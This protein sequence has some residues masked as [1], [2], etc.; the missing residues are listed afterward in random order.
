MM[1]REEARAHFSDY[2]DDELTDELRLAFEQALEADEL[3][4]KEFR[5]FRKTVQSL[6][7]LRMTA[8][9][10]EFARKVERRIQRRS[11]GRFFREQRILMR[12]PFE[13]FSFVI[14]LI[15]LVLY[16]TVM[17]EGKK[18]RKPQGK[19][20]ATKQLKQAPSSA[21]HSLPSPT[22]EH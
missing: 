11:R 8:P 18:V 22:S 19:P 5:S 10:P 2:L 7:G 9:P 17:L 20:P 6:S 15:L 16:M 13:W 14:I 3:L 12:V 1:D 4:R 21:P